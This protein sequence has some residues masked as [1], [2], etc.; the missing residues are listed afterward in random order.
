[1]RG[2]DVVEQAPDE[3][4]AVVEPEVVAA[5]EHC[6]VAALSIEDEER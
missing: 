6:E 3:R 5:P 1:M 4:P 2:H